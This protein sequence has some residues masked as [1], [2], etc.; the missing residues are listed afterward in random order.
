MTPRY[1]N[2]RRYDAA[3]SAA[4]AAYAVPVALIKAVIGAESSFVNGVP[5]S[6]SYGLMQLYPPT[7]QGY[8]PGV[9]AA[10]LQWDASLNIDIGTRHLRH[11]LDVFGGNLARVAS[12]YNA[13][14]GN[15]KIATAPYTFCLEWKGGQ[16]PP[17]AVVARDCVPSQIRQVKVGE[18]PNQGYVDKVLGNYSYFLT[19][20]APV[21]APD[22]PAYT[23]PA[24]G[25][26]DPTGWQP[27]LMQAGPTAGVVAVVV[28][29][30]LLVYLLGKR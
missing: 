23:G 19:Q 29:G 13:G 24:H 20:D 26:F 1:A 18:Y 2:E 30:A 10:A 8:V 5:S 11:L 9:T 12:A 25:E 27:G 22:A 17:N 14:E 16:K 15:A 6:S 4:A 3:I 28:V 7:A 21:T